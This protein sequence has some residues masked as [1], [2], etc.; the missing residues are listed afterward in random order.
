MKK[1]ITPL[2]GLAL[3]SVLVWN[4]YPFQILSLKSI[5]ALI[6]S[7]AE[8][9]DEMILLESKEYQALQ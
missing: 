8:V 9:Q 1:L 2:I 3:L 4:P 7:R 5:D 6:M